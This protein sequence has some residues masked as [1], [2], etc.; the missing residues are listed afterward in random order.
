[1]FAPPPE[2]RAEVFTRLPDEF[3][4]RRPPS[5]WVRV[6]RGG[7]P[8]DSF[9]E[10]PSFDRAGNLYVVDIPNGRIFRVSPGG[11]WALVAEY[12]GEPNGLKIHR[13]GRIFVADHRHGIMRLDP[14]SGAVTPVV[15]RPGLERFKGVND[16]VFASSGDLYFTDQGQT[17]L[18]DPTGRVYRLCQDGRLELLLGNVPSPNG[19][20]LGAAEDVLYLAVTRGNSIWRVPLR[21]G[22]GVGRVGVFIQL[23]GGLGGPDGLAIDEQGGLAVAHIGLGTVWL[24]SALGEPRCRIRSPAGLLTTNV[25]YGGPDRRTLYI[26]EAETG[27]ILRAE[28]DVPGRAM[29]SH[30]A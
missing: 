24:F 29:F 14:A 27:S 1:M 6:Q 3:R 22:V 28:L 12:D 23:S 13:D 21:A 11:A 16:L 19:L 4:G 18:Q 2:V 30:M 15:D 17:G 5:E 7:A 20:V 8:T 26:T 25:A 10:G 9:L